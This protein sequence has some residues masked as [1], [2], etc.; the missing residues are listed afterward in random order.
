[1]KIGE[2]NYLQLSAAIPKKRKRFIVRL[3]QKRC[4]VTK[5]P[6]PTDTFGKKRPFPMH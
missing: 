6:I 1:M 5:R 4:H 3:E 2:N